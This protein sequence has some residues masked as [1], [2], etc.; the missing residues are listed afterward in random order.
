MN[1]LTSIVIPVYNEG[2]RIVP[3]LRAIADSVTDP[4]EVLVVHDMTEDSTVPHVEEFGH[5]AMRPVLNTLGPGPA[6]AIRYGLLAAAGDVGVV[7]MADASDDPGQIDEMAR[8]V[9]KGYVVVAASRYMRGGRQLGGP[10]VKRTMSRVAGISLYHLAAVGTRDATNSFKAYDLGF[11]RTVGIES[12]AGFEI[13]IELV[14]KARRH[15]LPVTEIATEWL[16][17]SDGESR[18]RVLAWTPKYLRWWFHA[19]GPAESRTS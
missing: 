19:F 6:N 12:S 17:R 8:L 1:D 7:T 3:T 16:D 14:A 13:G 11:V 4:Y 5:P 15:R 10:F 18:F 2:E 9:R